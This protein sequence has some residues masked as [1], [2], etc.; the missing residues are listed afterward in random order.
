MDLPNRV[1]VAGV[2]YDIEPLDDDENHGT[3]SFDN[4]TIRVDPNLKEDK[5]QQVFVHELLHAIFWEAGYREQ[6]EEMIERVGRVLH[7]VL[8]DNDIQ[9]I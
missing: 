6:D 1:K 9:T 8:R 7:Q 4:L 2:H 3:C 5:R